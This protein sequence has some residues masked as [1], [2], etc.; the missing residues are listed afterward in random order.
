MT[1]G[2]WC[3]IICFGAATSASEAMKGPNDTF[4]HSYRQVVLSKGEIKEVMKL[5]KRLRVRLQGNE[6]E[7]MCRCLGWK[8][9]SCNTLSSTRQ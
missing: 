1:E 2:V 7:Y 8:D 6:L 3:F 9:K 5:N 4:C